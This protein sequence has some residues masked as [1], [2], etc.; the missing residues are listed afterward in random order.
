MMKNEK[1]GYIVLA[2]LFVVYSV[3]A[4]AAPF[5]MTA[6]FWI[7]YL[8]GVFAIAA[9]LYIFGI[10]F[11]SGADVKSKFYGFPIVKI[12]VIYL[13]V[14]IILSFV[15]MTMSRVMPVWI[16][17]IVDILIAAVVAVG[18]I[19]ADVMR[20]EIERQDVQLK[21]DVTNMRALQ[22]LTASLPGLCKTEDVRMAMKNLADDF[23]DSDP[24]SSDATL[25]QEQEL[26]FMVNE[27]QRALVDGDEKSAMSFCTRVKNALVERNRVCKL[28]K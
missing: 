7:A 10:S 8:F 28:N 14:Q 9:Q 20:D 11:K 4:F 19:A 25:E 24:V 21:K 1:R 3:V 2:I 5:Q 16:A 22:S 26:K 27:I 12:G 6:V 15:Q 23:H 18:C 13:I 17:V